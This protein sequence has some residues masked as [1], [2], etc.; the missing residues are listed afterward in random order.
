MRPISEL[1]RPGACTTCGVHAEFR[2]TAGQCGECHNKGVFERR[3]ARKAQL[4]AE[5]RCEVPG[6]GRRAS[7]LVAHTTLMC[8]AHYERAKDRILNRAAV[9]MMFG[10][11]VPS[12][13]GLIKAAQE[14]P[15]AR[16]RDTG[17]DLPAVHDNPGPVFGMPVPTS[18]F[19]S[20]IQRGD[21]VTI[22]DRFGKEHSGK[23]VMPSSYGGWVLNMGG[24]HGTP[25]IASDENV[26]R[27][28]K[29][30]VKTWLKE[31]L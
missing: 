21:R 18:G 7:Q 4:A 24:P 14:N 23:A 28:K 25:A 29:G 10:T 1:E 3:A 11:I 12:K 8:Q 26:T 31:R 13:E 5:P 27:V 6:C 30:R 17:A 20:K 15:M 9:G 22:V 16:G 2:N 19:M